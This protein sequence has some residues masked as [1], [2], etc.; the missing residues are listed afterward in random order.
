[1]EVMA[2]RDARSLDH[3][4]L[5]EIRRLAVKRVL[6]GES[7]AGVAANV[8]VHP[9][10]VSRWFTTYCRDGEAALA[11]SKATGRPP[12]LAPK[13]LTRLRHIIVGKNPQQLS[14]GAA[15]WTLPL[16]GRVIETKFGVVLHKAT[17][18]RTLHRLGITPQKPIRRAFRR[19][20][21]ECEHWMTVDFPRIVRQTR[22]VQGVLL[23]TDETG[24]HEDGPIGRTWGVRGE[25]P[26]VRVTGGRQRVNVISAIT[27]RGRLWFRCYR[28]YLNAP[29]YVEF[30]DALLHDIRGHLVLVM[31]SHPAHV[32]AQTRRFIHAHR[33][34]LTVWQLPAY[35]PDLNP[36]EHVWSYVK[37][38]FRQRPLGEKESIDDRVQATML[39]LQADRERV[40]RCFEH[41]A[42]RYVREALHW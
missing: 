16:V 10:T 8:E 15:L 20:D 42:V 23:F 5:E 3:A 19:D 14:F 41:P 38:I 26:V 7:Q 4:T 35:A 27:P 36:D 22:R 34:R 30:L 24:V 13:Q 29:R 11:S 9:K 12:S 21:A 28:G 2:R 39:D 37:G 18:S 1:M 40:R 31:D 32:A 33:D 17:V 25:R 6:A